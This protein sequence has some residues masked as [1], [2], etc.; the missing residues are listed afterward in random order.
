MTFQTR[1]PLHRVHEELAKRAIE[2][3]GGVLLLHPVMDLIKP[4]VWITSPVYAPTKHWRRTI[5]TPIAWYC[6]F[7]HWLDVHFISSLPVL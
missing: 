3:V 6:R 5:I 7:S 1:N 2:E 4:Y